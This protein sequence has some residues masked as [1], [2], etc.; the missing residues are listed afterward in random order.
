MSF[1]TIPEAVEDLRAGKMIVLVDDE[2]RENEGDLIVAAEKVTPA[3]V[4]FMLHE[5]RG[6]L[7]VALD[8][9][10]CEKLKLNPQDTHNTARRGTAYTV[11]VDAVPK[12]GISTGVSAFDRATT[13]RRLADDDA[14]AEDFD[15][16]GHI[17]PIRAREGGVLVRAGH[18]EGMVD[19]CRL[20]GLK[21]V[22]AGIEIMR[23]DGEMA[24]RP[25]LEKFCDQHKLK[26]CTI[27]DLISYRMKREQFVKRIQ[28]VTLPTRW[29]TFKLVAY[30]S[31]VDQQPHLALCK[32]NIGVIDEK[33]NPVV[34]D[35]PVL[36]RVHSE[37]LTGDVFG[38]G[39]CDCGDQLGT[40]MQM[41]EQA[42]KGVLVYLRQEGRGIGLANKLHAYALQEK[43]LDT[44]EANQRLG[45]PVD[46]RDYGI[47]SQILRDLGLRKI[48]IMTNNPKKIYGIEGYG[49]TV[50]E[51]VP[52]RIE[53]GEHNK[54]YLATKKEKMGHKL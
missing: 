51:E 42:G 39:K 31:V 44:V 30:Q 4:N 37:C 15:R 23:E 17:Q 43:G 20:A 47:G 10:S 12:F 28:T 21:S 54:H 36:V 52:V 50:V 53:P 29:G 2:D 18:T 13:I 45:L 41:I 11:S 49:L 7:F 32:G 34:H 14:R 26:M 5:A 9:V 46:K 3:A 27:A 22:G 35:E 25:E 8:E 1:C 33:G 38:S 24:R 6:M 16:P 48:R 19:L 40:A